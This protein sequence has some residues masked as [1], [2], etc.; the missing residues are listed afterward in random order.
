MGT[1]L[2]LG[3]LLLAAASLAGWGSLLEHLCRRRGQSAALRV[4]LGFSAVLALGGVLNCTGLVSRPVLGAIV[5]V[6]LAL[7]GWLGRH[8]DWG[9]TP[10]TAAK[11]GGRWPR[12]VE[13]IL[14]GMVIIG[15]IGFTVWTQLPPRA[16]NFHD[17]FQKYLAHP[18]RQLDTGTLRGSP[19]SALGSETLGGMAYLHAFALASAPIGYANGIDAALAFGALMVLV[20]TTARTGGRSGA[21]VAL[22]ATLLV[23]LIEPQYVNVSALYLTALL[24]AAAVALCA[25]QIQRF[26]AMPPAP[27]LGL[28]YGGLVVVKSLGALFSALHFLAVLA[29]AI[30]LLGVRHGASWSLRVALWAALVVVPW[31]WLHLPHYIAGIDGAS[32]VVPPGPAEERS[33]FSTDVLFYGGMAA[34]YTAAVAVALLCSGLQL[35]ERLCAR[36]EAARLAVAVLLFGRALAVAGACAVLLAAA[37]YLAGFDTSIRYAVP[38]I[39]GLVP[40]VVALSVNAL[41]RSAGPIFAFSTVGVAAM[42]AVSFVPVRMTSLRQASEH[43]SILAF[44]K[45]ATAP[46]YLS[47]MRVALSD[48]RRRLVRSLQERVPAEQPLVAWIDQ[49]Y[50]LDYARNPIFDVDLAGLARSWATLP[51]HVRHVIWEI[52]GPG[53]RGLAHYEAG[54]RG[55]GA[56][57]R[58]LNV[59]AIA[60]AKMLDQAVKGG[61]ILFFDG[62]YV[63]ARLPTAVR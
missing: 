17:D 61:T 30:T 19:L 29:A 62:R 26:S 15:V 25:D 39:L 60:F 42:V 27:C 31:A 5:V 38:C 4:A 18:V 41:L 58:L 28:L 33:I 36:G 40:I 11:E 50:F 56:N 54:A 2:A 23:V 21:G 51:D 48:E 52:S 6:G 44:S 32:V 3:G 12:R 1:V 14:V 53:V 16:L 35:G 43:G 22:V 57:E 13:A 9:P 59:R 20:A 46:D 10:E 8:S 7:L 47:Y 34:S 63:V 55:P 49:P 45:L 24:L 37:P